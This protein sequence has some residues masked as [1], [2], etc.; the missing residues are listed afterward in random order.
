M[1]EIDKDEKETIPSD[2]IQEI[3]NKMKFDWND[4]C[5]AH[6]CECYDNR[7]MI[8]AI[9]IYLDTQCLKL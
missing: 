5:G 4:S 2:V 8:E 6:G 1:K 7:R 9:L 3:R